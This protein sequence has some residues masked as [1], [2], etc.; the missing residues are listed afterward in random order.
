MKI[1]PDESLPLKLRNSFSKEHE[2]STVKD[3]GWLGN[4]K[5]RV[6]KTYYNQW[7]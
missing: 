6:I 1:L 2:I 3:E 4:E 5:W 7:L